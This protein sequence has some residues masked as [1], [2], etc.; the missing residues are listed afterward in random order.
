MWLS[1]YRT[2]DSN[3][4]FSKALHRTI[5]PRR[6][7]KREVMGYLMCLG[8]H[9]DGFVLEVCRTIGREF[10]RDAEGCAHQSKIALAAFSADVSAHGKNY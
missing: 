4:L 10:F 2:E 9:P 5:T 3:D 1:E 6:V 8:R 7:R